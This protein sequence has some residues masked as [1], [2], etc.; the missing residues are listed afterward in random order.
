MGEH[1]VEMEGLR[2]GDGDGGS[3]DHASAHP[4]ST[5]RR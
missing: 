5:G 1:G 4:Y 3:G 2:D